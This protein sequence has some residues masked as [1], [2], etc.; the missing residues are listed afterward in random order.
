VERGDG[1]RSSKPFE[2]S[3][4]TGIKE[5]DTDQLGTQTA[6]VKYEARHSSALEEKDARGNMSLADH[7]HTHV[8]QETRGVDDTSISTS[9]VGDFK[10]IIPTISAPSASL[11]FGII[12]R[13]YHNMHVLELLSRDIPDSRILRFIKSSDDNIRASD[14]TTASP[15][16]DTSVS[17]G[18]PTSTTNQHCYLDEGY[19][20]AT[21][22]RLAAAAAVARSKV[23]GATAGANTS[24]GHGQGQ[25][26]AAAP[27]V[28]PSHI[29]TQMST[30][31][32]HT[33]IPM[34]REAG[35]D[36]PSDKDKEKDKEGNNGGGLVVVLSQGP[37]E[38]RG[39]W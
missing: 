18:T 33:S 19:V 3:Q 39:A 34:Q 1:T 36:R 35:A 31:P 23:A 4:D 37:V 8:K 2:S 30:A 6:P 13:L 5:Y 14:S 27:V 28:M 22:M 20:N 26:H 11:P 32:A 29:Q 38:C 24:T 10:P 15:E 21:Q 12:E 17:V 25:S 7:N 16:S 9:T